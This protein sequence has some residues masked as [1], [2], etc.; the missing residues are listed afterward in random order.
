MKNTMLAL[1]FAALTVVA[2]TGCG[3]TWVVV[4][5]A[6]PNTLQGKKIIA[7]ESVSWDGVMIGG[8]SSTSR[9][10]Y[11]SCRD[12]FRPLERRSS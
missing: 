10:R 3:P 6:T 4:K 11:S 7:I 5:Q 1:S 9:P 8:D 12:G 2:G